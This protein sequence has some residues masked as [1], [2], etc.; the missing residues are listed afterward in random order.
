M[1]ALGIGLVLI[2][3]LGKFAGAFVG[4][5]IGGLDRRESLALA[6]GMNARGSTEVIVAT[7]GLSLGVLNRDLFSLIVAMAVI[8]TMAM[9]PMLRWALARLPLRPE[10][11]ARLERESFEAT[12]FVPGLERLLVAA[13]DSASGKLASRLVGLMAGARGTPVTVMRLAAD[14][15][16]SRPAPPAGSDTPD[17]VAR[18]AAESVRPDADTERAPPADVTARKPVAAD[19]AAVA[20]EA[21]K[22]YGLMAIGVADMADEHG[23]FSAR[24]QALAAGFEGPLAIAA[25]RGP[26]AHDPG[27]YHLNIL[28]PVNG[29]PYAA[30]ASDVALA[31]A[32]AADASITALYVSQEVAAEQPSWPRRIG[33]SLAPQSEADLI[34]K[35]LIALAGKYDVP[36]RTATQAGMPPAEAVLQQLRRGDHNLLVLGV[37][38]RTG[39]TLSFGSTATALARRCERSILFVS[40]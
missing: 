13:D 35:H 26:H 36:V 22:G 34:L 4:G 27:G 14:D 20:S 11:A 12:G 32:R 37:S 16:A 31:I 6:C 30:R 7:I 10:E 29:T 5:A 33:H 15:V 40:S 24:V 19:Q 28:L 23:A 25:A 8:T 2:A 3:S 39:D 18:D 21:K 38:A 17:K 9:P 1:A